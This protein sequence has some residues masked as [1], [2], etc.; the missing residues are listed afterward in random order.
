MPAETT[1]RR[2]AGDGG[3]RADDSATQLD[4]ECDALGVE[5][6]PP[7]QN[8]PAEIPIETIENARLPGSYQKAVTALNRCLRVDEAK[9]W[10]D[11]AEAIA[12]YA[13]MSRDEN[14]MKIALRIK[15]RAIRR[16]GELLKQFSAPGSRTDKPSG[17]APTRLTQR[18]AAERARLSKDQEV[19]AVRVASVPGET[20]EK[21]VDSDDPPTVTKLAEM[22]KASKPGRESPGDG[23]AERK[24]RPKKLTGVPFADA[25]SHLSHLIVLVYNLASV[26]R[27]LAGQDDVLEQVRGHGLVVTDEDVDTATEFL[28][29]LRKAHESGPPRWPSRSPSQHH[30]SPTP[31]RNTTGSIA[32]PRPKQ[33][34][35]CS[36][37]RPR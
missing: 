37:S 18:E 15:S 35:T 10:S 4:L 26:A 20:F 16:C 7:G 3:A 9:D 23:K 32:R 28:V 14:L 25:P 21:L 6:I 33:C 30:P 8:L 27:Q 5:I 19:T 1:A 2:E 36:A 29:G 11:K 24:A 34:S 22:G 13:R 31:S 12:A 17:D